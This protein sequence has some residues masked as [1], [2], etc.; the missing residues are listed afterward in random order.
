MIGL[1]D[2]LD[3][4]PDGSTVVVDPVVASVTLAD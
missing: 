2:A 1:A 3:T 4:I